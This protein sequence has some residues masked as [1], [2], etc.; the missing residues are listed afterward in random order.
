MLFFTDTILYSYAQIF[1]S[2]RRW[3]GAIILISTFVFP[4]LGLMALLGVIVSNLT[5]YLLKFDND[6]IRS[7]FY[8]F[9]GILF[10]A[11]SVYYFNLSFFLLFIIPVFIVL[12]FFISAFL[13]HY[14]AESFNLPGL[15]L[16]FIVTLYIFIIFLSNYNDINLHHIKIMNTGMFSS[17][18]QLMQN[19]F[20]SLSLILFQPNIISG[21]ILAVGL[22]LFSRVLFL[23]SISSYLICMLFVNLIIPQQYE[24]Y[25]I[26]YGFNAILVGFALG[27]SLILPSGKSFLLVA[28]ASLMIVIITAFFVRLMAPTSLPVLVLPFN[29]IVLA[30]IYSLKFRKEQTDLVLLYFK[31]G[32]PEENLYYHNKRKS[33][34]DRFKYLYP[35][36]PVF[37]DWLITQA[38]EG[39]HTH[40]EDYKYAWDFEVVDEQDSKFS[41]TGASLTDYYSFNLPVSAP[42]DGEIVKVIDGI[43]D[44]KPGEAETKNNWGNTVVIKHEYGLFSS[45]SHLE[46]DSIKVAVGDKVKKG[47]RIASCGNSGR[48][49]I[50]HIHLQFQATD[51]PGDKTFRFPIA[52]YLEKSG[53]KHILHT[54]DYPE[55]NTVVSN[56]DV[57]KT[58]KNAFDL[59][60]GTRLKFNCNI[61]DKSFEEE[62]EVKVNILNELYIESS[63]GSSAAFFLTNKIFYFTSFVGNRNSALYYFYLS[64]MQVPLCYHQNLVWEDVYSIDQLPGNTIRYFTEFLLIFK[65]FISAKGSF[66]Y[67][68]HSEDSVNYLLS[69]EI[70]VFGTGPLAFYNKK[71]T[72]TVAINPDGDIEEFNFNKSDGRKFTAVILKTEE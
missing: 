70:K 36:L 20:N 49:P 44:N 46:A 24:P 27:G 62:W 52:H 51:K 64:A 48:S 4:L 3:F 60:L 7:G 11:A 42:L 38:V 47:V 57:H 16:P 65:N 32:S 15:S 8:G 63:N 72:G 12:T 2:N 37:G 58:I 69:N 31:P 19:Y 41:G 54:F 35:E 18:P 25:A 66:C 61:E 71:Y 21:I 26:L 67:T 56:L 1:F 22:L 28:I 6:K 14:L 68:E 30:A 9:N 34:F 23:L 5:A 53:N 13:E 33:R 39:Q 40:K 55:V 43:P 59:K 29:F 45:L 17:L 50:P 10:G